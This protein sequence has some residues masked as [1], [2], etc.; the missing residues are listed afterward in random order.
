MIE[1]VAAAAMGTR[2]EVVLAGDD[3]RRLRA[4]GEAALERVHE[5]EA[6]LNRFDR[7]SFVSHL[8]AEAL[9]RAVALDDEMFEL[10]EACAAAHDASGGAVDVT[11]GGLMDAVGFRSVH[12]DADAG[13]GAGRND[14]RRSNHPTRS[15]LPACGERAQGE[16]LPRLVPR[17]G[18]HC[19]PSF[20]DVLLDRAH[21]TVRFR[22]SLTLDFG[23]IGKGQALDDAAALLREHGV[24]CALLHGGTSSVVAIGAP[25]GLRGW[26]VALGGDGAVAVLRDRALSVSAPHG[27]TVDRGGIEIGHVL[28]PRT[29]RAAASVALVAVAGGSARSADAWSTALLVE[30]TRPPGMPGELTSFIAHEGGPEIDGAE[31][32]LFERCSP[33]PTTPAALREVLA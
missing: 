18:R 4:L 13:E 10:F 21:R 9:R 17:D 1:R 27:R 28:D 11:V 6:R 25:P 14:P 32:G 29:G 19:L 23:A 33:H 3:A 7:G 5:W 8:N 30:G 31:P 22:R 12:E 16:G 24:T 20:T 2:F 26:R 15:P